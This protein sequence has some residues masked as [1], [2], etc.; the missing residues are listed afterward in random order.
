MKGLGSREVDDTVNGGGMK[1]S[2]SIDVRD[3]V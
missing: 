1:E 2:K 3:I